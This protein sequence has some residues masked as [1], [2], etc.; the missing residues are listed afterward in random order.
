MLLKSIC[1]P[2]SCQTKNLLMIESREIKLGNN[3]FTGKQMKTERA[4]HSLPAA[5]T[6]K[7]QWNRAV[8]EAEKLVGYPTSLLSIRAL[9]DNDTANIAV[10]LRK[11]IGSDHPVLRTAKRLIYQGKNKMQIRGLIVLLV[12]RAVGS[13]QNSENVDPGTGVLD[14]QRKLAEI[15]EMIH[16]AHCIHQSVVN[17]PVDVN[18]ESDAEIRSIL[19][20]LEYGNKISILS[21]DYLLANACVGLAGLRI[22]KIVELVSIAIAEFTQ[23]EFLGQQDPQGRVVPSSNQLGRDFWETRARLSNAGLLSSG[24]QGAMLIAGVD[25]AMQDMAKDLGTHLAL[26]LRAH[27]EL[28]VFTENGG[29]GGGGP[30]CLASAPV[31]FHLQSDPE[32]LDYIQGFSDDLSK[33]SYRKVYDRVADGRMGMDMADELCREQVTKCLELLDSIEDNE[34]T[35]A[36]RKMAISLSPTL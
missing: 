33:M 23:A 24:C 25:N 29:M 27:D 7:S 36:L 30:F 2:L 6:Q 5:F 34:A 21:G 11:L 18:Q 3:L 16:T 31:L 1:R 32:L 20:Q 22:T 8:S 28:Q 4:V 10:H 12:S 14:D 15:V 19:S 17:V 9:L 35:A 26:A 13:S